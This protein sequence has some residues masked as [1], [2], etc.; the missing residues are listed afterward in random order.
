MVSVNDWLG[1][2][3]NK[4]WLITAFAVK[5]WCVVAPRIIW[6][7]SRFVGAC[8]CAPIGRVQSR[9]RACLLDLRLDFCRGSDIK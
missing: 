8:G 9:S 5:V 6:W 2:V 3:Q 4:P 7:R 1:L